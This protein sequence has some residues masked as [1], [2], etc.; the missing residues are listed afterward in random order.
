MRVNGMCINALCQ[1]IDVVDIIIRAVRRF[2][3]VR[4]RLKH[5]G[6]AR[7]DL[8]KKKMTEISVLY[9]L[10]NSFCHR[11]YNIGFGSLL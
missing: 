8:K 7:R 9:V 2:Y 6:S 11:Q 5:G 10:P 1:R 3:V 4:C